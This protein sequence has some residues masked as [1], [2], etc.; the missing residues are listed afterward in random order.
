[1]MRL[2]IASVLVLL[3][4]GAASASELK[5]RSHFD[6]NN[7]AVE[8]LKTGRYLEAI[9]MLK[10]AREADPYHPVLRENLEFAY[11]SAAHGMIK[12]KHYEKAAELLL[13]AQEFNDQ[14]RQFWSLRGLAL[15]EMKKYYEA[16]AELQ[17][18]LGMGEPDATILFWLA[19]IYY[20][21]DRMY[22]AL[23]VL[24]DAAEVAPDNHAV[25]EMLDKVRRELTV[26]E[27][28]DK[29]YGGHF[30]I[31]F[32]GDKN[33]ALGDAVLDVLEE[34]YNWVGSQLDYYPQ[35]QVTVLL[36]SHQEFRELTRSPDW[37][38]GLYDGKIRLPVGGISKVNDYVRIL[39][40]HEYMHVALNDLAKG[41]LP[42]WLNEGLA[43][44]AERR[45]ARPVTHAVDQ[46]SSAKQLLSLKRLE[47]P[48]LDLN[49]KQAALA[50][51]QSYSLVRY[52]LHN[53]GWHLVGDLLRA[54]RSGQAIEQ[55]FDSVFEVYGLKY[56]EFEGVWRGGR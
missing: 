27:K 46:D 16:E 1:M 53:Y 36:Y 38:G 23:D 28:M 37:A 50:Y 45:I 51:Q 26:E 9:E 42:V 14:Q 40:Y 2:L 21:T 12:D 49:G 29:E 34:A 22:D 56:A 52:L 5:V 20:N 25:V 41:N 44:E 7:E 30:I 24:E 43:Q 8:L 4:L 3:C 31:T 6:E 33:D 17:E 55:A 47:K 54:L 18:A 32:D 11:L 15:L 10:Q 39:L 48:F 13:E 19:K 35:E